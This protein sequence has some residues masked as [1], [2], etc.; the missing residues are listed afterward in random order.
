MRLGDVIL[1]EASRLFIED[2]YGAT[3]VEGIAAAAG[4][5][6]RTFYLRFA[7]KAEVFEAVVLRN[8]ERSADRGLGSADAKQNLESCLQAMAIHLLEWILQPDV[9]GIYRLTIAEVRRFPELAQAVTQLAI[10]DAIRSFEAV[11]RKHLPARVSDDDVAFIAAQFMHAVAAGPFHRAV[12]GLDSPGLD[13][14]K[15]AYVQRA[16]KLFL[17]GVPGANA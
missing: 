3:S 13:R 16:I 17:Q 8:V 12:Q 7:G 5:S 15:R 2:G 1:D 6:K 14:A 10:T 9:L 4:I 11:F